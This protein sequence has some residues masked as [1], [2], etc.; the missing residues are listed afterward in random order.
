M[1][2]VFKYAEKAKKKKGI[3]GLGGKVEGVVGKE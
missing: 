2:N 1:L 3:A